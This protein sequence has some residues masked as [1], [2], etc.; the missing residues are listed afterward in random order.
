MLDDSLTQ[1]RRY[2]FEHLLAK[3]RDHGLNSQ[4][5]YSYESL[6]QDWSV[7][8]LDRLRLLTQCRQLF[9]FSHAY[10]FTN[11][12]QWFDPLDKLFNFI[13]Q[14]YYVEC[15]TENVQCSPE[16]GKRWI[17]SLDDQLN[18][19]DT[20][21]D[22]YALAFVLL[23]FSYYFK[24]TGNTAA[25]PLI[26][27]THHFLNS[28]LS[29]P[30]GGFLESYPDNNAIRRQNP[31]MHLLEGYLAA[32]EVT[33]NAEYRSR[34]KDLL[35]LLTRYFFDAQHACLREFFNADWTP[36]K[37]E[38]HRIEP[39]HH[40]EW[41]WLLH[42]AARIFPDANYLQIAESL[43]QTA[44][45]NG[46]DPKGGIY[47]QID[48]TG[49]QVIDAEKRIWPITEYLKALCVH[50]AEHQ[51]TEQNIIS[52]LDFVFSH[53]LHQDGRWHEY[54]DAEN[55]PKSHPLPGTSS[56]HIFLGLIEVLKWAKNRTQP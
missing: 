46:F 26:A 2:L 36:H 37:D 34:I 35:D 50:R 9:T 8:P 48:A 18:I 24:A 6:N 4:S 10:L 27:E 12:K 56:Y 11:D 54:L 20:R 31:H 51:Q 52:T 28:H 55:Q 23:S 30:T 21:S 39:G 1:C 7:N 5:G 17:F 41:I 25:L 13:V 33:G 47:N 16:T 53:Y 15:S 43:W 32:Y 14:H 3:W 49:G 45:H 44:C 42:Q 22:C 40:F 19:K 38:G 29:S